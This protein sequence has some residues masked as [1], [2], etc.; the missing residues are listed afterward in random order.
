M[1]R[2]Y[3]AHPD[4]KVVDKPITVDDML[5]HGVLTYRIQRCDVHVDTHPWEWSADITRSENH[6]GF[7]HSVTGELLAIHSPSFQEIQPSSSLGTVDDMAEVGIDCEQIGSLRRGARWFGTFR[8]PE[9]IELPSGER[10][11]GYVVISDGIDGSTL[12][13]TGHV[14]GRPSCTNLIPSITMGKSAVSKIKHTK[15]ADTRAHMADEALR[16]A[17]EVQRTVREKMAALDRQYLGLDGFDRFLKELQ[18]E[19]PDKDDAPGAAKRYDNVRD[20]LWE[21]FYCEDGRS[22]WNAF[23][24]VQGWEQHDRP[25][26]GDTSREVRHLDA[27][28]FGKLPRTMRAYEML[29]AA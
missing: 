6:I 7:R 24:T 19:R 13:R 12:R 26:R 25:T 15:N 22:K 29:V 21:R 28:I 1:S 17:L 9:D 4:Y 23:N 14:V 10:L 16:D 18:G 5:N 8:L 3:G 2:M 27:S 11:S 20:E